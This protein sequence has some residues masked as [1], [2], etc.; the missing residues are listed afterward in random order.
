MDVV[1]VEA[2]VEPARGCPGPVR[3]EVFWGYVDEIRRRYGSDVTF[4]FQ[5]LADRA[6][7][8]LG[9]PFFGIRAS[10]IGG[11]V[12]I[13]A[14]LVP[15]L[16][17]TAVAGDWAQVP[18]A[19]WAV[20]LGFYGLFDGLVRMFTAPIDEPPLPRAQSMLKDSMALLPTMRREADIAELAAYFR[21][22]YALP[23]SCAVGVAVSVTTLGV[24]W[25]V[26]PAAVAALDAGTLVLVAIVLFDF[27]SVA[28]WPTEW[29]LIAREAAY[30]H[31]L[32]WAS[33]ADSPEVRREMRLVTGFGWATGFWITVYLA[34]AIVLLSWSSPLV[35]PVAG[36]FFAFGYVATVANTLGAR[37]GIQRIVQRVRDARLEPLR[38]RIE[39]YGADVDDLSP[40]AAGRLRNL[41]DLHDR[42]RDAPT[43]PTASRTLLRT[44][45]GLLVPAMLFLLTVSGEVYAERVLDA[46]LP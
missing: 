38:R 23:T 14:R 8:G 15:A 37:A 5:R 21:R 27:G 22:W 25:L 30:D 31:E 16:V 42:I 7:R 3:S 13:S 45:V 32:F 36:G 26:A 33:P 6:R 43:T 46:I 1:K 10:V 39:A 11:L 12:G 18:W 29:Q 4:P 9:A 41:L 28:V 35:L 2:P 24:A 34:V 20:V 44:A 19:R 17:V 40:A